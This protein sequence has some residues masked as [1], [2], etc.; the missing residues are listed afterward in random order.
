MSNLIIRLASKL[1]EIDRRL[2]ARWYTYPRAVGLVWFL[3]GLVLGLLVDSL[4]D[5]RV[6]F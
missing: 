3:I 5:F 2:T 4:P 1:S 6:I